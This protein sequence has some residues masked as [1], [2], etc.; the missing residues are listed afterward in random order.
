MT[1]F[2]IGKPN[3][4]S[5]EVL[6]TIKRLVEKDGEIKGRKKLMKIMFLI[7][8][9]DLKTK[10][11]MP[12]GI[13]GND[14]IIYKYGPFSFEVMNKF[15]ELKQKSFINEKVFTISL[16]E[17]GIEFINKEKEEIP[18]EIKKKINKIVNEYGKLNGWELENLSLKL[19]GI[20]R[21][22]K[23]SFLGNPVSVVIS[24]RK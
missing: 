6:Y 7:E 16:S 20:T 1:M 13:L 10:K 17:K 3:Q 2:S 14:F 24:E 4:H 22:E 15:S 21:E 12:D 18:E 11:L 9:L 19:L 23:E 5:L 8:H